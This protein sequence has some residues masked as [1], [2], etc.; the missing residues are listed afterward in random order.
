MRDPIYRMFKRKYGFLIGVN[1][2][3]QWVQV[4]RSKG[5]GRRKKLRWH[6]IR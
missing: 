4:Y 1:K 6:R 3:W 5:R 2:G